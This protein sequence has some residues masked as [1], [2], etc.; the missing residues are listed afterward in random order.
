MSDLHDLEWRLALGAAKQ[1]KL[2]L[3]ARW[4]ETHWLPQHPDYLI[5][6]SPRSIASEKV[7]TLFN[8]DLDLGAGFRFVGSSRW[9]DSP[10][11]Q[12]YQFTP[13][14]DLITR[15]GAFL[16]RFATPDGD[17]LEILVTAAYYD[18]DH[19]YY[20]PIN[21][22][23]ALPESFLPQWALFG[24]ECD[25]LQS[26]MEPRNEVV[27]IGGRYNASFVPT[28]EWDDVILPMNLKDELLNDVQSFFRKGVDVYR[29]LKLKPFRKLLLAGVPGTG[30]TMLCSALAKWALSQHYLVIYISS[31]DRDGATFGKIEQALDIAADSKVPTL[32][33]LEELD[34]YLKQDEKA[35]VLNVLDGSESGINDQGTLLVAT[36]NYPEAIDERILKRPGRLDRIF[37]IPETQD[38][39]DA[40]KMLHS[41][42]GQMWQ[43]DHAEVAELLVGYP[44]A[45][46]REVAIYAL[47]QV[48]YEDLPTLSLELLANSFYRLKE[49]INARDDFLTQ[50]GSIG[51]IEKQAGL[52]SLG[53]VAQSD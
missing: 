41:Y 48:A 21:C 50:R 16:Y 24:K 35:L 6:W 1:L 22:A 12:V 14:A 23:A 17:S 18:E 15:S 11:T 13:N 9:E 36:T 45:F 43:P 8:H 53:F 31:A 40:E 5:L 38:Q 27:I 32:I 46:I 10:V 52:P 37:I 39:T 42:L 44:G 49:Q 26:A 20:A 3:L 25:R 34:A 29:R 47:T 30:K 33:L 28:V 4:M 7:L 51:F 19:F 2:E